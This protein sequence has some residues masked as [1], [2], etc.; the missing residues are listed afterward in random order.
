VLALPS[1]RRALGIADAVC[2]N[3]P[4]SGQGVNTAS[5]SA[6]HHRRAIVARGDRPFDEWWMR[7]TADAF[8]SYADAVTEWTNLL[9]RPPPPHVVELLAAAGEC[10][11]LAAWLANGFDDPT[12][13]LPA[14]ADPRVAAERID[15]L[16]TRA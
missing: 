13:V 7:A 12:R 6:E 14:F 4:I 9:L 15:A 2:L 16:A 11:P 8:S 1:G 3:D 5:K 10:P